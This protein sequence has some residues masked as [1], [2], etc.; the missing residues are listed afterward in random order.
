MASLDYS[1]QG[2]VAD[3]KHLAEEVHSVFESKEIHREALAALLLFQQAA[4]EE[5][6]TPHRVEAF[7]HYFK[8]AP[9]NR[10]CGSRTRPS[11]RRDNRPAH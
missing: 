10:P 5:R 3:L 9:T 2:R 8:K 4:R 6:L 1:K 11:R 7:V